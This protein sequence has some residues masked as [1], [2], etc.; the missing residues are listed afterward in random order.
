MPAKAKAKK[1]R[2]SEARAAYVKKILDANG[3]EITAVVSQMVTTMQRMA[4][5]VDE[6]IHVWLA[7]RLLVSAAMW[8]IRIA[9]LKLPKSQCAKCGVKV[10]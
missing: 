3:P 1:K 9:G 4:P 7:V 2:S 8:D 10:K 5:N 6:E